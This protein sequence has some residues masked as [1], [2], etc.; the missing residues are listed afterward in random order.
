MKNILLIIIFIG[1]I[2]NGFSQNNQLNILNIKV[3]FND[4]EIDSP[5]YGYISYSFPH[6]LRF[7]NPYVRLNNIFYLLNARVNINNGLIRINGR[8]TGNIL[9]NYINQN[10]ISI[11]SSIRGEINLN[12]TNN[13]ILIIDDE[14]YISIGIVQYLINGIIDHYGDLIFLNTRDHNRLNTTQITNEG[15]LILNNLLNDEIKENIRNSELNEYYK[16][17]TELEIMIE[18]WLRENW[19]TQIEN[20]RT[21][22]LLENGISYYNI[23]A[24]L[25]LAYYP[26]YLRR[27]LLY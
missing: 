9:I 8:Q 4:L 3:Y 20:R 23:L 18:N 11:N 17:H 25:V 19:Q 6:G 24:G 16:M 14:Y 22:L 21:E 26:N 10:N 12:R 7:Y 5:I 13:S 27:N 15:F 2:M 1:V